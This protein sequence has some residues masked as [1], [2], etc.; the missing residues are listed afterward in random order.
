MVKIRKFRGYL[1]NKENIDKII[2]PP[3]DVCNTEEAREETGDNDMYYFHVEK[4]DIDW[5]DGADNKAIAEKGKENLLKFIEKE[6]LVRDEAERIYI[7]SQQMGDHIQYGVVCLASIDDYANNKIKKHEN[8]IPEKEEERTNLCDTQCA[9]SS[10]VFFSFRD[11]EDISKKISEIVTA[12]PYGKVVTKDGVEHILW[13]WTPE[14]SDWLVSA[15]AEID[16]IYI[17]DGH[18]RSAAAYNVGMR[19]KQRAIEAGID[20]TGEEPFNYFMTVVFPADQTKILDYNRLLKNL[21][22]MSEGDFLEKMKVSFNVEEIKAEDPRPTEKGHIS[23]Y[24]GDVWY[25][26]QIKPELLSDQVSKNLDYNVLTD[27]CFKNILG[28][29]NIKKD[30]RVEF[31]GGGRGIKYLVNRCHKDWKAAFAMFP[32]SMEDLF[33]VADA[34]ECMPPKCTWFEPKLRS[35]FVVNVFEDEIGLE[36]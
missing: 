32:V 25:D 20:V 29:E 9:N 26:L 31:V 6:Y 11:R 21:N 4:P 30:P 18:H 5:E 2:S 3:Y 22:D 19:R 10:P 17:A 1:A 24:L 7:Y 15:F 33:S 27:F 12:D 16:S 34:G 36:K 8:T 14:D 13:K 28:I 23:M 35:G